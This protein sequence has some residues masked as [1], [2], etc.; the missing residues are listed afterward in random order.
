[1][2]ID[3]YALRLLGDFI[4]YATAYPERMADAMWYCDDTFSFSAFLLQKAYK[5]ALAEQAR[6]GHQRHHGGE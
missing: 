5:E 2:D 6:P 4:Y 1:M 3:G